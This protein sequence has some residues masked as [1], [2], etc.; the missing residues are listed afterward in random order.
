MILIQLILVGLLFAGGV[1]YFL[2]LRTRVLDIIAPLCFGLAI[3]QVLWP[4]VANRLAHLLG[5]ERGVDLII[6]LLVPGLAF[7]ILLLFARTRELNLKLTKTIR[8]LAIANA[9]IN[10]DADRSKR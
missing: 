1:L 10:S 9:H 8:E 6:Y 5:L 4:T 3:L 7:L 2:R